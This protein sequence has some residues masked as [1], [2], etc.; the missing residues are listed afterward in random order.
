MPH[1]DCKSSYEV[2][3]MGLIFAAAVILLATTTTEAASAQIRVGAQTDDIFFV[4]GFEPL[5]RLHIQSR[6]KWLVR[7]CEI[8][9]PDPA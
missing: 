2:L 1:R 4:R 3:T 6:E 8:F 9:L 7:G 5:M